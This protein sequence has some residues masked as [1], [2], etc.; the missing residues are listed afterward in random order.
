[1]LIYHLIQIAHKDSP[2]GYSDVVRD[3][4]ITFCRISKGLHIF[5]KSD[6]ILKTQPLDW[7]P[8]NLYYSPCNTGKRNEKHQDQKLVDNLLFYCESKSIPIPCALQQVVKAYYLELEGLLEKPH[9]Q[10]SLKQIGVSHHY[11]KGPKKLNNDSTINTDNETN[12][13]PQVVPFI[14]R[15][16]PAKTIQLALSDSH[17]SL[18]EISCQKLDFQLSSSFTKR[19][20]CLKVSDDLPSKDGR[21]QERKRAISEERSDKRSGLQVGNES[22]ASTSSITRC[23]GKTTP[24]SHSDVDQN[25]NSTVNTEEEVDQDPSSNRIPVPDNIQDADT[26]NDELI[27]SEDKILNHLLEY[28]DT[29]MSCYNLDEELEYIDRQF[30]IVGNIINVMNHANFNV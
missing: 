15:Q 20:Q 30:K 18:S 9:V 21:I 19:A 26:S 28:I 2:K 27:G 25:V 10:Q 3:L 11:E 5:E 14:P 12:Q 6:G 7:N 22:Q 16:L 8:N 24:S 1:M 23:N 29:Y 17:T 13:V 4:A